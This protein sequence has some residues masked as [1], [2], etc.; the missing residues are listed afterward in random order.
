M[1]QRGALVMTEGKIIDKE[2]FVCRV[3]ET[4][5]DLTVTCYHRLT[6]KMFQCQMG[7]IALRNW[8]TEEHKRLAKTEA[9]AHMDPPLLKPE[10]KRGLYV[11]AVDHI[12]TDTRKGQ[13]RVMFEVQLAKS[14]KGE[15]LTLLQAHWRRCCARRLIQAKYDEFMVKVQ[16]EPY[17]G[18]DCYYIDRRTGASQWEKP[19]LLGWKDLSE[20]PSHRWVDLVYY[21]D[22]G[23][24]YQHFVNPWTGKFAFDMGLHVLCKLLSAT[25]K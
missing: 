19:K 11:W 12:R 8:V 1:G 17:E 21:D 10:R 22:D 4:G 24:Y 20:Q 6:C 16:T 3:Y 15:L 18:A 25:I 13:F 9:E 7:I 23:N 5:D 2:Y 14:R